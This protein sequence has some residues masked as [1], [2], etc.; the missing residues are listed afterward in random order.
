[1]EGSIMTITPE[2][3]TECKRL[4]EA[5][6]EGPWHPLSEAIHAIAIRCNDDGYLSHGIYAKLIGGVDIVKGKPQI[7][8]SEEDRDFIAVART[9]LPA[10]IAEV[11]RLRAVLEMIARTFTE[12]S[13]GGTVTLPA[14]DYQKMARAALEPKP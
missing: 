11:E 3:M 5:A 2:Q 10:L 7:G 12:N 14:E 1:M 6:T 8:I 13:F 9:A 4:C